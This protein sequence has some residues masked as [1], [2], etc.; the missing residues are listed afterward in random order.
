MLGL[1]AP[2]SIADQRAGRIPFSPPVVKERKCLKSMSS[3][4][5]ATE[6][7]AKQELKDCKRCF[8]FFIMKQS[9]S[10][11][12]TPTQ[13]RT[14]LL[15]GL[16][17]HQPLPGCAATGSLS[18]LIHA[19]FSSPDIH[20]PIL[21]PSPAPPGGSIHPAVCPPHQSAPFPGSCCQQAVS[22]TTPCK[23]HPSPGPPNRD[24]LWELARLPSSVCPRQ[25]TCHSASEGPP[26][27]G[28]QEKIQQEE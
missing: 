15:S 10:L 22:L 9:S 26:C 20:G 14:C 5:T 27:R 28:R 25:E 19:A 8:S 11:L 16:I 12:H 23:I 21:T 17:L 1:S 7:C 24:T 2:H 13:V 6:D 3:L 4:E 18:V